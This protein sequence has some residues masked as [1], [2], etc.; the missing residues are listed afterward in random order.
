MIKIKK[1]SLL[2][3]NATRKKNGSIVSAAY[4]VCHHTQ[5]AETHHA[6]LDQIMSSAVFLSL[7]TAHD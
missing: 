2:S 5:L 3:Q 1:S 4:I 7:V 6:A